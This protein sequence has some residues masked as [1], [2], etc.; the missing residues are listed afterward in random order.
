MSVSNAN[1]R[2][3]NIDPELRQMLE[4][5]TLKTI[6][7]KDA[8]MRLKD[9]HLTLRAS[10]LLPKEKSVDRP[11]EHSEPMTAAQRQKKLYEDRKAK[12]WRKTWMPPEL[13]ELADQ[14]GGIDKIAADREM[15]MRRAIEA[16]AR[17]AKTETRPARG[18]LCWLWARVRE[19]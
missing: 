7:I 14:L 15:W 18:L 2:F 4:N 17:A 10:D 6:T 5:R 11:E 1:A 16:E 3:E 9:G 19:R 8:A 13:L 12:G